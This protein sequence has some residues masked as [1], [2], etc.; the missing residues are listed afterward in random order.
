M[1]NKKNE[2]VKNV[3]FENVLENNEN[4]ETKQPLLKKWIKWFVGILVLIVTAVAGVFAV[5]RYGKKKFVN[6]YNIGCVNT[7][8]IERSKDSDLDKVGEEIGVKAREHK[9]C[10]DNVWE[11][12][13]NRHR[14][15]EIE[16]NCKW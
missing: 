4:K 7:T 1:E 15:P 16:T 5:K 2:E 10:S 14:N 12:W 6:G 13:C 11:G 8:I 9:K 3:E